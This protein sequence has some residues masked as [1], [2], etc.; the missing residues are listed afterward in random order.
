MC[1]PLVHD[2]LV[3]S[4]D[5]RVFGPQTMSHLD[6]LQRDLQATIMNKSLLIFETASRILTVY[7]TTLSDFIRVFVWLFGNSDRPGLLA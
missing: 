3:A 7:P 4:L 2:S 6:Y 1:D 5:D